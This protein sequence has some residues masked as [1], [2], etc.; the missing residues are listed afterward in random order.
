[1]GQMSADS[2]ATVTGVLL[3]YG[4]MPSAVHDG[5]LLDTETC[6]YK[7]SCVEVATTSLPH[8]HMNIN[9]PIQGHHQQGLWY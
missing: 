8:R 3:V 6:P 4:L 1:M 2:D 7:P 5:L 9:H